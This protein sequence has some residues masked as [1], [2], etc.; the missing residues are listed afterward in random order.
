MEQKGQLPYDYDLPRERIAQWPVGREGARDDARL[1]VVRFSKRG[2][3]EA[4]LSDERVRNLPQLLRRGDLLV[5]NDTQVLACRFYGRLEGNSGP[6]EV[7]LIRRVRIDGILSWEALAKPLRRFRCG[8]MVDFEGGGSAVVVGRD[9]KRGRVFLGPTGGERDEVLF[10]DKA[11]L[12]GRMP[13]PPYIRRGE[14]E[15]EDRLL[16]QTVFAREAGSVAA[17]TAGLH[18]TKELLGRLNDCGIEAAFV[19][20]HVGPASFLP[21]GQDDSRHRGVEAERYKVGIAATAAVE[22][23]KQSGRRVVAVGTTVTRALESFWLAREGGSPIAEGPNGETAYYSTDLFIEPGYEFRVVDCLITNFHQPRST[24]L[25]LV[26]AFAGEDLT[27]RAY[28]HA[29]ESDYRFL[30]YGDAM[31]LESAN[32]GAI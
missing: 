29:L 22:R 13:I 27:A 26:S 28:R 19:T 7:L 23:A 25:Y 21:V 32:L 9:E 12:K 4:T 16:Y 24:H 17:P 1:L 14:S 31:L 11:G 2:C 6:V 20:L 18:F 30:S 15:E 3:S 8:V 5:L 10:G